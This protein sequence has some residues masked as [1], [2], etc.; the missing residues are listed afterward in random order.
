MKTPRNASLLSF[1]ASIINLLLG[2][3]LCGVC[4]RVCATC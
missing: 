2:W 1:S 3:K 4:R